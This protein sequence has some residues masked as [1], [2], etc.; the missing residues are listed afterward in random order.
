[1]NDDDISRN[2]LSLS[3]HEKNIYK[4]IDAIEN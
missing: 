2:N 3:K 4:N 1:M